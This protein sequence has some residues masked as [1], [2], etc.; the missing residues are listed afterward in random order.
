MLAASQIRRMP[1]SV[2]LSKSVQKYYLP[3]RSTKKSLVVGSVYNCLRGTVTLICKGG[4]VEILTLR[5]EEEGTPGTDARPVR[6]R[7]SREGTLYQVA[8]VDVHGVKSKSHPMNVG[9]HPERPWLGR[10]PLGPL[11]AMTQYDS[12]EKK[13]H[14]EMK[15]NLNGSSGMKD[16]FWRASLTGGPSVNATHNRLKTLNVNLQ[17]FFF[18]V[19]RLS[20]PHGRPAPPCAS[21]WGCCQESIAIHGGGGRRWEYWV[22]GCE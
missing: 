18:T 3:P 16:Q 8:S 20:I 14:S 2:N 1:G 22:A 21:A 12:Y 10:L 17:L 6:K 7:A 5:S 11:V 9:S 13:I 15:K 4:K 19:L